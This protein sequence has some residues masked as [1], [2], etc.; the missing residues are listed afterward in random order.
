MMSRFVSASFL[1][2]SA[3]APILNYAVRSKTIFSDYDPRAA[4]EI[5]S[6]TGLPCIL[7]GLSSAPQLRH[8]QKSLPQKNLLTASDIAAVIAPATAMGG[9][10]MLAAEKR[11]IPIISVAENR[12]VLNVTG[13][14]LGLKNEIKASNYLEAAGIIAALKAGI[15]V[16]SLRRP[17][18]RIRNL[19]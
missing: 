19:N 12:T 16:K 7:L 11:G 18:D 13:E 10:P 4:G 6:Q 17:L 3:H 14:K 9:I 15:D 1:I 5:I 2:P 8:V